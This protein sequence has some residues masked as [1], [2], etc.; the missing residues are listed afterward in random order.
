MGG[1][2]I[3]MS[4]RRSLLCDARELTWPLADS[5]GGCGD[6]GCHVF[7]AFR[8]GLGLHRCAVHGLGSWLG[9]RKGH[10]NEWAGRRQCTPKEFSV[11]A[12]TYA[13]QRKGHHLGPG[14]GLGHGCADEG[15]GIGT[16]A[17]F[18]VVERKHA[19]N[20][21]LDATDAT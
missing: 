19:V 14:L 4:T 8:H 7:R 17:H 16:A 18:I 1:S 13:G 12:A 20:K 9:L 21:W 10:G 15:A 6:V 3:L 11:A 2:S 5:E